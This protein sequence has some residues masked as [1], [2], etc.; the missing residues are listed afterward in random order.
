MHK[1]NKFFKIPD[2]FKL[3]YFLVIYDCF[4]DSSQEISNNKFDSIMFQ[5]NVFKKCINF[6]FFFTIKLLHKNLFAGNI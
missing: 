3:Y 5:I 2:A 6:Y 4:L 1:I